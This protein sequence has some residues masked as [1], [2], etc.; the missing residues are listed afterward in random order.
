M[1]R[2]AICLVWGALLALP[3]C[4]GTHEPPRESAVA[5][6][7]RV[8]PVLNV[9][10]LLGLSI[11][12]LSRRLG[13]RRPAPPGFAD[14]VTAPFLARGEPLDSMAFFQC[15]SLTLAA[16]YHHRSRQVI[17][18]LVLGADEDDLMQRAHLQTS[19]AS[20]LVLPVFQESRPTQLL[21]LRVVVKNLPQ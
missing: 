1:Q 7:R 19:T 21:G 2:L 15:R 20:Y 17:D 5:A 11:D 12:G 14:P 4:S 8:V 10:E 6:P 9:P 18:I 3:A 16:T 13:P